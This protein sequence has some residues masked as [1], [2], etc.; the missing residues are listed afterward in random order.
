MSLPF[1]RLTLVYVLCLLVAL[2]YG[3]KEDF[4]S[5][6][7]ISSNFIDSNGF[8]S[9]AAIYGGGTITAGSPVSTQPLSPGANSGISALSPND[10]RYN[11][12]DQDLFSP[13]QRN[14][15]PREIYPTSVFSPAFFNRFDNSAMSFG[16]L[17]S[18]II[19]LIVVF[20]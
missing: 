7:G 18:L 3:E 6:I 9:P 13:D 10:F 16:P 8:I 20:N 17:C 2:S 19:L 1:S 4:T 12:G 15:S 5:I 11:P 14:L